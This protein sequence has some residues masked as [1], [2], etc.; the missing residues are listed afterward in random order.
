MLNRT[1]FERIRLFSMQAY[2]K[3]SSMPEGTRQSTFGVIINFL[4][5][6]FV[7]ENMFIVTTVVFAL[8]TGILLYLYLRRHLLA[9]TSCYDCRMN[10]TE[11]MPMEHFIDVVRR[12]KCERSDIIENEINKAV[13]P[14]R[15]RGGN[16]KDARSIWFNLDTIK[17]FICTIEKYSGAL[18]LSSG[19]LGIRIYYAVYDDTGRFPRMHT[20]FMVPTCQ[21]HNGDQ[22]DMDPRESF[23]NIKRRPYIK[24]KPQPIT[25]FLHRDFMELKNKPKVNALIY[26]V[27]SMKNLTLLSGNAENVIMSN[28]SGEG[29]ALILNNGH[30]CP[31]LCP[32]PGSNTFDTMVDSQP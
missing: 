11:G 28:D 1:G 14:A 12:Y 16:F 17:T 3:G 15:F 30:L 7:M 19:S 9:G 4:I 8:T 24:G 10:E 6:S 32:R 25:E 23:N 21:D 22:V 31:S 2:G 27:P 5:K 18:K 13:H 26:G 29:E 20:L